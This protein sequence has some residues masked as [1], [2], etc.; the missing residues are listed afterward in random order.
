M[1]EPAGRGTVDVHAHRDVAA[2]RWPL[3]VSVAL[4]VG[5]VHLV[6]TVGAGIVLAS[7]PLWR[8][9]VEDMSMFV[10]GGEAFLREPAW[11]FPIASTWRLFSAGAPVSIVY[12]DSAPWVAIAMKALGLQV[13]S[14]SVIGVV[15]ALS[16][17]VQPV[18][19]ALL[20]IAAG[21]RR[22]E[23]LLVGIVL[24][25]L[26]P[27]WYHRLVLHVALS[28]H[29]VMVLALALA[30]LAIRRGVSWRI[31]LGFAALGAFSIGVHSYLFV[32]IAAVAAGALLSDVARVGKPAAARAAVGLAL[33]L[34]ASGLSAWALG[35]RSGG[36]VGGFGR[37]SMNALSPVVPQMSGLMQLV[38]GTPRWILDATG[39]QY[40]GFNYLG[41]GI[42]LC[43]V[44]AA[45]ILWR[46]RR[47]WS[48]PR[49]VLP[50]V[51]ALACLTLFALSN[52]VYVRHTLVLSVPL[53]ERVLT[54]FNEL[55][56]SGR[57]FWP[58][59]Y[60]LLAGAV[61][62]LDRAPRRV[63]SATVLSAALLLQVV[64]TSVLRGRLRDAYRPDP[65]LRPTFDARPFQAGGALV[66]RNLRVLPSFL[67]LV[68]DHETARQ[69][70]LAVERSG[71]VVE[72]APVARIDP[73]LCQ[74]PEI[75]RALAEQR[76]P[77]RLDL[78]FT[79]SVPAD[80]LERVRASATCTAAQGAYL[81]DYGAPARR[82]SP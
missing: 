30:A 81:C 58:V 69:A 18:A 74:R 54:L 5:V 49:A 42:L 8:L 73:A 44:A 41:A 40:E 48:V 36:G 24:G 75:E 77:N 31:V 2:V 70:A 67:C 21:V 50:L 17:V 1:S 65:A 38:L 27:A 12:T 32:M 79:R 35:Y 66:G 46:E 39:R 68:H 60:T 80:L 63:V 71:G 16:V 9:P 29:W 28:S 37:F 7:D 47:T 59:A 3:W 61:L 14:V 57:M 22:A 4:I 34:A 56:S 51:A 15:A 11:H 10:L 64:D 72:G 19:V 43:V 78:L 52:K 53:P 76:M 62:V 26:L 25:S 13:G 6:A 23:S 33:F 55:R 20:L 82:A 45:I